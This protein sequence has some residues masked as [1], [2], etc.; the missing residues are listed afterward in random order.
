MRSN[1]FIFAG[2][3]ILLAVFF[4]IGGIGCGGRSG[5][6]N[7][8]SPPV[9][10]L[11]PTPPGAIVTAF[12]L[13]LTDPTVKSGGRAI[14][15]TMAYADKIIDVHDYPLELRFRL[16]GQVGGQWF[17]YTGLDTT[18]I[19]IRIVGI[20]SG[21]FAPQ[22]TILPPHDQA[23]SST[24]IWWIK[25]AKGSG[26]ID[27][28]AEIYGSGGI[29]CSLTFGLYLHGTGGEEPPTCRDLH[30]TKEAIG[31][32]WWDCINGDWVNTGEP[33]DN[34]PPISYSLRIF[35]A[36][37]EFTEGGTINVEEGN[38]YSLPNWELWGSDGSKIQ[39]GSTNVQFDSSILP[40]WVWDPVRS[41][42]NT[43]LWACP[44]NPDVNDPGNIFVNPGSYDINF[45]MVYAGK[46][47]SRSGTLKV[48]DRPD[49][50]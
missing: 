1:T 15:E 12:R 36:Q 47:Y 10:V 28:V 6:L 8:V 37:G 7:P 24:M 39:L 2:M 31:G 14:Y 32:Y 5:D 20:G 41:E 25:A 9:I 18:R 23:F 42:I 27:L 38:G 4:L 33:V 19:D 30:P 50:P 43:A 29:L 49:F 26:R 3:M 45:S 22:L 16:E 11:P 44:E 46:N 48:L 34:P 35:G 21:E 13:Q 40:F 17:L